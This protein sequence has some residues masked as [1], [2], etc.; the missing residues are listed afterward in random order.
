MKKTM[1]AFEMTNKPK[2]DKKDL[3]TILFS[4]LLNPVLDSRTQS[5]VMFIQNVGNYTLVMTVLKDQ[6][7]KV[8]TDDILL[9][10]NGTAFNYKDTFKELKGSETQRSNQYMKEADSAGPGLRKITIKQMSEEVDDIGK[11]KGYVSTLGANENHSKRTIDIKKAKTPNLV[12]STVKDA[13]EFELL[14][15]LRI[16]GIESLGII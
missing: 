2:D 16:A 4:K 1:D 9:S 8:K 14:R 3:G 7:P 13:L 5:K 15:R 12:E 6:P 10:T 11:S